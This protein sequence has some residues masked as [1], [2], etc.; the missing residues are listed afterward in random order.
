MIALKL[1]LTVAGALLLAVALAIP[2]YSLV[3][4]IRIALRKAGDP[5]QPE[6]PAPEIPWR[7][8]VALVLV[9]SKNR[10]PAQKSN[11]VSGSSAEIIV[12]AGDQKPQATPKISGS[13]S[14]TP[15]TFIRLF[16]AQPDCE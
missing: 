2:L 14:P 16:L 8:S 4:R 3:A 10:G 12:R 15:I 11:F 6:L 7:T 5:A 9:A 1:L 13:D